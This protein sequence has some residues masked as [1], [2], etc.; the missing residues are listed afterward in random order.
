MP[1][2]SVELADRIV[3]QILEGPAL[4]NVDEYRS[5]PAKALQRL[6]GGEPEVR[7]TSVKAA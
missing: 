4:R 5:A 7:E 3:R 1:D 2:E 6:Y